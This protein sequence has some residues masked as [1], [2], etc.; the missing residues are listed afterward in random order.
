MMRLTARAAA[1]PWHFLLL[2]LL[3]VLAL[4]KDAPKVSVTKFDNP[5]L[6][7]SYFEDS[8]IVVFHD[9]DAGIIY[10]SNDAGANWAKVEA[11]P[12][13]EAFLLTTH[14]FD[15]KSAF[16]LTMGKHHYK[17]DDQGETWSKF[18]T[19][20]VPSRFQHEIL[21]FHAD[22]PKRVIFNGMECDGIF[23][24]E[25]ATYTIDG[26]KTVKLLR[27]FTAG[28]WWA[29]QA[30]EFTTGD[31][32]LDKKRVLCIIKDPFSLLYRR[33]ATGHL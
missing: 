15:S 2:S 21:V 14:P 31:A 25:Q 26:F 4:A 7:L 33:P 19:P 17:T 16:V 1:P 12:E 11:V 9:V 30:P 32:D 20:V 28:C 6:G 18:E 3:W 5:P 22:D 10:R 24:D 29:K 27:A 8:D 23:C 13:G